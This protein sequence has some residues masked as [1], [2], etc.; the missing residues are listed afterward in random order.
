MPRF[1]GPRPGATSGWPGPGGAPGWPGGRPFAR[2]LLA[3]F[4]LFFVLPIVIGI[5]IAVGFAGWTGAAVAV[6]VIAGLLIAAALLGRFAFRTFRSVSD[7]VNSTGR[8]SEGD[9]SVRM[10]PSPSAAFRPATEAFNRMAERLERSDDLRRRLLADVGHELRTPL[11][12]MRG[13]LEAVADGVREV[14]DDEI[15]RL[16]DDVAAM[17]RLLDDLETLS[18]TEAGVLRLDREPIDVVE[19]ADVV[20]GRFR[21]NAQGRGVTL[22]VTP[23]VGPGSA[24]EAEVDP[25]R[26]GEVVANLVANALRAVTE[27]GRIDVRVSRGQVGDEASVVI[28]VADDGAGI[29]ADQLDAVFDRFHKG[30]ESNG[31]GLGLTI[32]RG[33]V[34]AHG[35]TIVAMSDV[36]AG[37]TMTVTLPLEPDPP[38]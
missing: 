13:E 14:D 11:T 27:G 38:R 16:L 15:R 4:A 18:T 34:E 6:V 2:R 7:L 17:E 10:S 1:P 24:I 23:E 29:P 30:S 26:I 25:H 28:E 12:I 33:L 20:A 9:Y 32:S 31:S 36:G 21:T 5:V 22:S 8:L 37:T 3:V 35:G 19:L